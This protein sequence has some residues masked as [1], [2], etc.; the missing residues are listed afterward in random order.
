VSPRGWCPKW[1]NQGGFRAISLEFPPNFPNNPKGWMDP[2][3]LSTPIKPE[4]INPRHIPTPMKRI[5][6]RTEVDHV[7]R[8][9]AACVWTPTMVEH[10]KVIAGN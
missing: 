7:G 5:K 6:F 10:V 8:E 2:T 4:T 1:D 9:N 3:V